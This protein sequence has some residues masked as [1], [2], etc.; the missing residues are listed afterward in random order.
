MNW[1]LLSLG[2]AVSAWEFVNA[3]CEHRVQHARQTSPF[4][5]SGHMDPFTHGSL[6]SVRTNGCICPAACGAAGGA[7]TSRPL[8]IMGCTSC[9]GNMPMAGSSAKPSRGLCMCRAP[10]AACSAKVGIA[11]GICKGGILSGDIWL[12]GDT[13]LAAAMAW[14]ARHER[15]TKTK[16]SSQV[17]FV[18]RRHF[19]THHAY[20][21]VFISTRKVC[22]GMEVIAWLG[23]WRF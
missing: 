10:A 2:W 17:D 23:V 5:S 20:A 3:C 15:L 13:G 11:F 8:I 4:V 21:F 16:L 14:Q 6:P 22:T 12:A 1:I 18:T 7:L 9:W 19:V